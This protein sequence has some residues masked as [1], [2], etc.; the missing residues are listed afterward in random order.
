[1][2]ARG[3]SLKLMTRLTDCVS[4]RNAHLAVTAGYQQI[5]RDAGLAVL[6]SLHHGVLG[7]VPQV[8]GVGEREGPGLHL[9]VELCPAEPVLLLDAGGVVEVVELPGVSRHELAALDVVRVADLV[10]AE[11]ADPVVV[12]GLEAAADAAVVLETA[13]RGLDYV[14][15]T[16]GARDLGDLQLPGSPGGEVEDGEVLPRP[17]CNE[18]LGYGSISHLW[19]FL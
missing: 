14:L 5:V 6:G 2:A 17:A 8:G 11:A 3:Q 7:A 18:I 1:M 4:H 10:V 19:G 12:E 16:T 15:L 13:V 9:L